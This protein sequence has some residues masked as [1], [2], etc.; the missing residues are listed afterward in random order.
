MR[1]VPVHDSVEGIDMAK[2]RSPNYPTTDLSTALVLI[3]AAFKAENRNKMSRA[4]LAKHIGHKTLNGQALTK[5][6]AVRAYGLIE[7]SSDELRLSDDAVFV[8]ASPDKV[9]V[10]YRDALERLALKPQLFQHIKK[11]F[12][13]TLPSEHNLSFW[14]VQQHFTQEAAGKAAK[15]F[16]ATMRLVSGGTEDYNPPTDEE[17]PEMT[18]PPVTEIKPRTPA[19]PMGSLPIGK[20][21]IVMNGGHL[22]IQASVDLVGLKQLQ[23]MLQK[24]AEILEMMTPKKDDAAN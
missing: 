1:Y 6:G 17:E 22:D 21:R 16:L 7:G 4:V 5:L 12:P 15:S 10:S 18:P 24:Y 19:P 2:V 3:R 11:Q 23:T 13:T 9:N 8:L 20:P 14:L